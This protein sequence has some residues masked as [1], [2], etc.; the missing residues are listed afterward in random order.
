M[1]KKKKY[2]VNYSQL[3]GRAN[4]PGLSITISSLQRGT[5]CIETNYPIDLPGCEEH[6]VN[7]NIIYTCS[8]DVNREDELRQTLSMAAL[9]AATKLPS[10]MVSH[11]QSDG[12]QYTWTICLQCIDPSDC[13]PED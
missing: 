13:D 10:F 2:K 3:F 1:K 12:A 5:I 4:S 7:G 11:T 9:K 6:E 8:A